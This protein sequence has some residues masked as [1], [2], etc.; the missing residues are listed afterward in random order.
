MIITALLLCGLFFQVGDHV[1]NQCINFAGIKVVRGGD[2][3]GN[4]ARQCFFQTASDGQGKT[5]VMEFLLRQASI[6][7]D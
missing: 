4:V 3:V 1:I 2:E 5:T 6:P 7:A